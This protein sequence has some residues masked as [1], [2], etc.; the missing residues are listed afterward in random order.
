MYSH[1]TLISKQSRSN[2]QINENELFAYCLHIYTTFKVDRSLW[3]TCTFSTI[4][5]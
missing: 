2:M 5:K 3:G 1:A 4:N